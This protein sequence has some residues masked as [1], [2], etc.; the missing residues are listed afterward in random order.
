[1]DR[2]WGE[3]RETRKEEFLKEFSVFVGNLPKDLDRFGLKAI[4]E[5]IGRVH[6]SYIPQRGLKWKYWRYGFVRFRHLRDANA[7]IQRYNGAWVRGNQ[8]SVSMA[9]PRRTSQ[10]KLLGK[11][12]RSRQVWQ[13][14]KENQRMD[15]SR[16]G[17]SSNEEGLRLPCLKGLPSESNKE[18]LQRTLVCTT[19]E[20]RDIATLSSAISMGV[21]LSVKVSALSSYKFLL[22]FLTVEEMQNTLDTQGEIQQWFREIKRWGNADI[23][24]SR[25]VWLSIVGVPPHAWSW[26]NFKMIAAIWGDPICLNISAKLTESF[27][28]MKVLIATKVMHRIDGEVLLQLDYEGYRVFVTES[29]TVSQ[30]V[31]KHQMLRIDS[32]MKDNESNYEVPGFEDLEDIE[33][34]Q[35]S[36]ERHRNPLEEGEEMV[37]LGV[38]LNSNSKAEGDKSIKDDDQ[39]EVRGS[40]TITASFSQNGYS[41]ELVKVSQHLKKGTAGLPHTQEDSEVQAPPG[42]EK[43]IDNQVKEMNANLLN[44]QDQEFGVQGVAKDKTRQQRDTITSSEKHLKINEKQL[45]QGLQQ[46]KT[47]RKK[48]PASKVSNVSHS[49]NES[50]RTTGSMIQLAV[51]SLQIGELLGVRVVGNKKAAVA[52]IT[53]HLKS[54]KAQ[55]KIIQKQN[56]L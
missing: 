26:E 36:N 56:Q 11:G 43:I 32:T 25:R 24:D 48:K 4:F 21:G 51:E 34:M 46:T 18:W 9:K 39:Q 44:T 12:V 27:E 13:P 50:E 8:I 41:E 47:T 38:K 3:K 52:R 54:R 14:K 2:E 17:R 40:R 15:L 19:E 5:K 35:G 20:P 10:G 22:T 53:D 23:C 7:S 33:G 30:A 6:D 55:G 49:P 28:V 29:E 45:N 16:N 42:F 37:N 1:M 31:H